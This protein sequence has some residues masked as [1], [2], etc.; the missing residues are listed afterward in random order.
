MEKSRKSVES[1]SDSREGLVKNCSGMPPTKSAAEIL[2]SNTPPNRPA[3]DST[4]GL[5]SAMKD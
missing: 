1:P 3:E 2:D 5:G 4:K